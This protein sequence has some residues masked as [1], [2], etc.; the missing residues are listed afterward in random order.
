MN[1]LTKAF[2]SPSPSTVI[3]A[4]LFVGIPLTLAWLINRK[5]RA[6]AA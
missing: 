3:A 6:R 2:Q 1:R 5:L 4:A